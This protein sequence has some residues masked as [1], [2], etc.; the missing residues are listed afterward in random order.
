VCVCVRAR[1]CAC[2]CVRMQCVCACA[3]VCVRAHAC[4]CVRVYHTC[5]VSCDGTTYTPLMPLPA[6][7]RDDSSLIRLACIQYMRQVLHKCTRGMKGGVLVLFGKLCQCSRSVIAPPPPRPRGGGG[8]EQEQ[9]TSGRSNPAINKPI[10]NAPHKPNRR[11][12]PPRNAR[13]HH[14]RVTHASW[15]DA[16]AAISFALGEGGA[17]DCELGPGGRGLVSQQFFGTE[18]GSFLGGKN[19]KR[20]ASRGFKCVATPLLHVFTIMRALVDERCPRCAAIR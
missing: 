11:T 6:D 13:A 17:I 15:G 4:A 2:A 3:R 1:V 19:R 18:F 7:R 5:S 16:P 10:K 9:T 8:Q 14:T 20:M 12:T